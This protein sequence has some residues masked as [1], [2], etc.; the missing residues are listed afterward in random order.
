MHIGIIGA[1][2]VGGT[3][4][5]RLAESGHEIAIA[6]SR[7]PQ[8]L[9]DLVGELGHRSHAVSASEAARFGDLVIV[10]VPF[11]RYDELPTKELKGKPVMDTGNYYPER[12][13]HY[14]ELDEDKTTSSEMVQQHLKGAHVVKAFNTLHA[15]NMRDHARQSSAQERYGIPMSGDDPQAK[16]AIADLVEELGFQPVDAG[17]LATGGRKQ[18]PGSITYEADFTADELVEALRQGS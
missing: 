9:Q 5:K 10:S 17:D 11:G 1:G 8:T 4:A 15:E 6:N 13:G 3:L 7:G 18:Q 12:D 14:P 16:R 2:N